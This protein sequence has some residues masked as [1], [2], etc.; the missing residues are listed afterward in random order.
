MTRLSGN[1]WR[2]KNK[3]NPNGGLEHFVKTLQPAIC[4]TITAILRLSL[5][6]VLDTP[7]RGAESLEEPGKRPDLFD[8][9]DIA[10]FAD[11]QIRKIVFFIKV[12]YNLRYIEEGDCI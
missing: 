11:L 6:T 12:C 9:K 1:F 7:R 4:R 2:K 8:N 5:K 10:V 3:P